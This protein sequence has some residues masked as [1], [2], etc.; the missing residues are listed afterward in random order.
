MGAQPCRVDIVVTAAATV[1]QRLNAQSSN[2]IG[3]LYQK[4]R[5][6]CLSRWQVWL[7]VC[8]ARSFSDSYTN[9]KCNV[10]SIYN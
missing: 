6:A 7:G 3:Q 2:Y 1:L 5:L 9:D 10:M 4:A 8:K